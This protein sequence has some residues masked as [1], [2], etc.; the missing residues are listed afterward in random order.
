MKKRIIYY[1]L[2]DFYSDYSF[3]NILLIPANIILSTFQQV[4]LLFKIYKM[5]IL[6]GFSRYKDIKNHSNYQKEKAEYQEWFE[7]EC[8]KT[9][10]MN[11]SL[12]NPTF[13]PIRK[14]W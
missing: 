7:K 1:E 12:F 5:D 11:I 8:L 10:P 13:Y 3:V 9:T 2:Y 14:V 6:K 4:I